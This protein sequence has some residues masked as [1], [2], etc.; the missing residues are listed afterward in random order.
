MLGIGQGRSSLKRGKI[1]LEP[2]QMK[3]N[4]KPQEA[5]LTLNEIQKAV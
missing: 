3:C 2:A 5:E 4:E 1:R